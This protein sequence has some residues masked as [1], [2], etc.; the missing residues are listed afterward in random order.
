MN[1]FKTIILLV[2]SLM[3]LSSI[4]LG[5][6]GL[7][8]KD[9][10]TFTVTEKVVKNSKEHSKYLIF[11]EDKDGRIKVVQNTDS[12]FKG[13]FN[14]SDIY[15]DIKVGKTY[16]F[17]VYGFRIPFLSKYENIDSYKEVKK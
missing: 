8:V 4:T 5:V 2:F 15:A 11:G 17:D 10:Y 13:K 16:H 9:D 7:F 3:L 1:T 14:S 6:A 12:L